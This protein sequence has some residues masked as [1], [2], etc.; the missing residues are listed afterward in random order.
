M[1][2]ETELFVDAMNRFLEVEE[3]VTESND[4][5]TLRNTCRVYGTLFA[6]MFLLF[7]FLRKRH[8]KT[9]AVRNWVDAHKTELANDQYGFFSWMW[10]IFLVADDQFLDECGMVRLLVLGNWKL[11]CCSALSYLS[12]GY[13]RMHYA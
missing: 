6:V 7:C 2:L 4:S 9:F 13:H 5:E 11:T 12:F 3:E 10:K 8:P 1:A